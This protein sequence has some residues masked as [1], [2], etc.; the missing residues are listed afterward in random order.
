MQTPAV[1]PPAP[2]PASY[3]RGKLDL[4]DPPPGR[5][6]YTI[7]GAGSILEGRILD[8]HDDDPGKEGEWLKLDESGEWQWSPEIW[9][10]CRLPDVKAA[11]SPQP[12]PQTPPAEREN[13]APAGGPAKSKFGNRK[14]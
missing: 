8:R 9:I 1:T 12:S 4:N 5:F 13:A 6:L 14:S 2:L 11:T 7:N 10:E 3:K